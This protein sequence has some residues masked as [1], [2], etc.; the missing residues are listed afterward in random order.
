MN[1]G[2]LNKNNLGVILL[3][4]EMDA[5]SF[6]GLFYQGNVTDNKVILSTYDDVNKKIIIPKISCI[7]AF[8]HADLIDNLAYQNG[9]IDKYIKYYNLERISAVYTDG[10]GYYVDNYAVAPFIKNM[11]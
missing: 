6:K 10:N 11:R 8:E 1:K 9:I 5:L 3:L 2:I 4:N 7:T